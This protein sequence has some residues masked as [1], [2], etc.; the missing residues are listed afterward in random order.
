MI[1]AVGASS[2][3]EGNE[4]L[5]TYLSDHGIELRKNPYARRM[6]KDEIIAHLE[7][8]EGL[9][10]GLEPLDTEVFEKSPKLKAVA[11]I[12]IG[13]DNVDQEAAKTYGIKVSNTPEGPTEAVAEMTVTSLLMLL[14]NI[15][16]H[17]RDVHQGIWK[18]R[19][20]RSVSEVSVLLVGY[21]RIGRQVGELLKGFGTEV[22]VY[23]K[24]QPD[25]STVTFEEG[26][27]RSDVISIH[28]SGEEEII[29]E[30]MF[31]EM[32]QGVIIL[33]SA[34]GGLINEDGLYRALK[35]GK[36]AGFWGDA[37]W[38]EPYHGKLCE[39]ENAILTPHISTYTKK[40]RENM[41]MQATK[42]LIRDLGL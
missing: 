36:A 37:F 19:I 18:K 15:E 23:D 1:V 25:L 30:N 35:D 42:N 4:T 33:N 5:M 27:A 28:A 24:Y 11:R 38:E 14:H 29:S 13:M 7:G 3:A 26:I 20:G 10:A 2:F 16:A 6:T 12:G 31:D 39:L 9:F 22:M 34:R 40:C 8:A 32:K 17:N 41:E 21:G